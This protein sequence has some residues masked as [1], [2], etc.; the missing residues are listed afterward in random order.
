M[1]SNG[2]L[3]VQGD[4]QGNNIS[5]SVDNSNSL[6]VTER[7]QEVTIAG[8][9]ATTTSVKTVVEQAGKGNNNTLSTDAS[10]GAIPDTLIGAGGGTATFKPLNNAPSTVCAR[11]AAAS[12][13][14]SENTRNSNVEISG[15]PR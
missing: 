12:T 13:V 1:F 2:M 7:G 8:A 14:A 15:G 10:L 4:N 6:H 5:V 9:A 11:R 3:F